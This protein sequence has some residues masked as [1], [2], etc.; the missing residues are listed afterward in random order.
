M[1]DVYLDLLK[2]GVQFPSSDAETETARQEVGGPFLT[3]VEKDSEG[4][5]SFFIER[6]DSSST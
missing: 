5:G 3:C 1:K 4:L 2:K 6:N